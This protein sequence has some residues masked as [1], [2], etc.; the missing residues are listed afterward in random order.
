MTDAA[1]EE[2]KTTHTLKKAFVPIISEDDL[3]SDKDEKTLLLVETTDPAILD[4]VRETRGITDDKA[5]LK[6]LTDNKERVFPKRDVEGM[7]KTGLNEDTTTREELAKLDNSLAPNYVLL[8]EGKHPSL[9]LGIAMILGGL[10]LAVGQVLFYL[11][12]WAMR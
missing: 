7:L 6:Y 4:T 1:F 2:D 12:R 11:R 10:L 9:G 5:A 3:L 8:Q